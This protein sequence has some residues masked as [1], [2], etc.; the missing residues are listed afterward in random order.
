MRGVE[1]SV[2]VCSLALND[3]QT[4]TAL[5]V[6]KSFTGLLASMLVAEGTLDLPT[7]VTTYLLELAGTAYAEATV[8]EVMDMT[9]PLDYSDDY[10]DPNAD[11]WEHATASNPL[12]KPAGYT[13][14]NGTQGFLRTLQPADE[15]LAA[16]ASAPRRGNAARPA[17]HPRRSP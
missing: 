12:P 5:P 14:P 15:L 10:A 3:G 7:T 16:R 17:A 4:A 6:T 11:V 8:C 1:R 13:S 9:T 2:S